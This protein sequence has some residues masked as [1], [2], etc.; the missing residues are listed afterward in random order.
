MASTTLRVKPTVP[1]M[2]F[3]AWNSVSVAIHLRSRAALQE[4][5]GFGA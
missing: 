4:E 2:L 3:F 1:A 5:R